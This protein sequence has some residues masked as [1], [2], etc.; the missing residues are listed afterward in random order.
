VAELRSGESLVVPRYRG[1]RGH[2]VGFAR[3]HFPALSQLTGDAGARAVI[4]GAPRVAWLDV[5]DP[6]VMRDIDTPADLSG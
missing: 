6:G 5:D 2:P 4:A 1:E 3:V